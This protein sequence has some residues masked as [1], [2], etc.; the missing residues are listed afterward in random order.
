MSEEILEE[1]PFAEEMRELDPEH[2]LLNLFEHISFKEKI[3]RIKFGLKQPVETGAYKWAKLEMRRF[4]SPIAGVVVPTVALLLLVAFAAM[5][6][7][8]ERK[9]EVQIIDPEE[10]PDLEEIEEIIEPPPDIPDPVDVDFSQEPVMNDVATPAPP[11]DFAPQPADFD[12]VAITKSP[13]MLRGIYGSRNPGSR[14]S[15]IAAHGGSGA[16]EA[17]VLRALRWLKKNQNANGAWKG[18]EPAMAALAILTYMAHGDTPASEEFGYTVEKAL[19]YLVNAQ[20]P[21][22]H[23]K[24]RDGHDYTQP[25]CAYAL[26]EAY[27]MTK[28]PDIRYAAE[29]AIK[30]VIKGQN[31]HGSFNYNLKGKTDTR[32][33]TTYASWCVQ[34]LKAAKMAYIEVDGLEKCMHDAIAGIKMNYADRDGYGGFAY[35]SKGVGKLTGAGVLCLQFLSDAQSKEC[36]GGIAWL[37]QNATVSW[38]EP[39]GSYS[40]YYWYYI[41]QAMFQ[42]GGGSWNA[43]N[44]KFSPELVRNQQIQGKGVSGYVDHLGNPQETGFWTGPTK[45]HGATPELDTMLCTLML[46]VYYRYLPTFK[47]PTAEAEV[48][49]TEDEDNVEVSIQI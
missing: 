40:I 14:G 47:L 27:G 49:L 7:T 30:V 36:Q 4:L 29:K 39:W 13:V 32:N 5:T 37:D 46:E 25:I 23:F 22:G 38:A 35:S 3:A 21:S 26:C 48:D 20:E 43:W 33:D 16:G 44:K 9:I 31:A 42:Q 17:A 41:T 45:G 34:A 8:P 2:T 15:A 18:T 10:I 6:P 19:H 24:G 12:S 28:V 11:T 1:V